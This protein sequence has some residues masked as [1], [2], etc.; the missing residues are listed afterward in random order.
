MSLSMKDLSIKSTPT[1][2]CSKAAFT[3]CEDKFQSHV[4][5]VAAFKDDEASDKQDLWCQ[6]LSVCITIIFH[7]LR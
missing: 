3:K 4:E 7:C 2:A 6:V 1:H 5:A